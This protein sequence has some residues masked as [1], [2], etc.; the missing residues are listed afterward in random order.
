MT[1]LPSHNLQSAFRDRYFTVAKK[2]T[3]FKLAVDARKRI[4]VTAGC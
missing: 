4:M 1:L 2:M 3:Y